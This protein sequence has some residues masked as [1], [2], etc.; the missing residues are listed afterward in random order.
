MH[1]S[2][3]IYLEIKFLFLKENYFSFFCIFYT[4]NGICK[5]F[6][7]FEKKYPIAINKKCFHQA[8]TNLKL[9]S[10][11]QMIRKNNRKIFLTKTIFLLIINT[12]K[13][14]KDKDRILMRVLI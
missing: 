11:C 2:K 4:K 9:K 14:T 8:H 5:N 12:L 1:L 3:S 6:D 10:F 13:E 7:I